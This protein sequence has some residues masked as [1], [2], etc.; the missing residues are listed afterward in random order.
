MTI[1]ET[2]QCMVDILTYLRDGSYSDSLSLEDL[3]LKHSYS[4]NVLVAAMK[5]LIENQYVYGYKNVG[6]NHVTYLV[7]GLTSKG[8]H[9]LRG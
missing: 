7:D 2:A 5:A 9:Y 1:E 8:R 4:K 6:N 3:K